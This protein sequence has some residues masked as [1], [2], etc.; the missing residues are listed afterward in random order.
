MAVDALTGESIHGVFLELTRNR[1]MLLPE[2]G[3][4]DQIGSYEFPIINT[5]LYR[6]TTRKVGYLDMEESIEITPE[7]LLN[8]AK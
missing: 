3:L 4:S 5:G 7:M 8:G 2:E 1:G 6:V